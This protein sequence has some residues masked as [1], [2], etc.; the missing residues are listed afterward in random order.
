MVLLSFEQ[1]HGLYV[2]EAERVGI[3]K[4]ILAA[5]HQVHQSPPLADGEAGLGIAPMQQIGWEQMQDLAGQVRFAANTIRSLSDRLTTQGWQGAD[6]WQSQERRYSDRFLQQVAWGYPLNTVQANAVHGNTIYGNTIY[7]N[8]IHAKG[9]H[10]NAVSPN[11][12][13]ANRIDSVHANPA[14]GIPTLAGAKLEPCNFT[15]LHQA[16][17]EDWQRDQQRV[18]CSH[19]PLAFDLDTALVR[20][21]S[22]LPQFYRGL[23]SQQQALVEGVRIWCKLPDRAA[24]L[25]SLDN[26]EPQRLGIVLLQYLQRLLPY[27]SGFPHQRE[28]LLRLVK[29]WG[30]YDCREAAIAA[31]HQA[32]LPQ[33]DL[34]NIDPALIAFVQRI[35]QIY[36]HQ[37]NQRN[38][39]TEGFRLWHQLDSR[40]TTLIHLGVDPGLLERDLPDSTAI[41]QAS[42]Q[43]DRELLAFVRQIPSQYQGSDRQRQALIQMVQLWQEM[44][45]QSQTID[46]L[47]TQVKQ[48]ALARPDAAEAPPVPWATAPSL[49]CPWTPENLQ[50]DNLQLHRAIVVDGPFT[51]AMAT[52]G[53]LY[54]PPNQATIEA[55]IHLA[56][57]AQRV[58]G[59]LGRPL[60][61]VDWYI[62][63]EHHTTDLAPTLHRHGLGDAMRFY[64]EGLTGNQIYW[65]LDPW[66][67]GGLGRFHQFPYLCYLD[68][69]NDRVRW[70][71]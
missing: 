41:Q 54:L 8:G 65:A 70:S 55:I 28:A 42:I 1:R 16:Y 67:P 69:R 62:P 36:R 13:D 20:W 9:M 48:M 27:Y 6:F 15:Q 26:P 24:T 33:T 17:L 52:H 19:N 10:A 11:P 32:P 59:R 57:L 39:L 63:P 21:A 64:G 49:S 38:A 46:I 60:A 22:R 71:I 23:N 3:H 14:V 2:Q 18:I 37:G 12:A 25:Q 58:Q 51:W 61:I 50:G 68:G 43:V 40:A 31:L 7:G 35:P 56:R 53:G 34:D 44:V 29:L 5:L 4:P 66:W 30:Q 45:S 47:L